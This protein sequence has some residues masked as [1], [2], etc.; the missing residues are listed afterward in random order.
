MLLE[1]VNPVYLDI[2]YQEKI[3]E[4]FEDSSEIQL[5]DFLRV[6]PLSVL[7]S[8][9]PVTACF[10]LISVRFFLQEE[11]FKEVGEALQKAHILWMNRGPP[12]KR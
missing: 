7:F 1:W 6:T 8:A 3:Q 10:C 5:K 12:N 4:E 11:K 2:S 9:L